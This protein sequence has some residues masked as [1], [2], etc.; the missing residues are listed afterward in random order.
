MLA[1]ELPKTLGL[2]AGA[3][4]RS[5]YDSLY[6]VAC[7]ERDAGRSLEDLAVEMEA[8]YRYFEQEK[9][10][11]RIQWGPAAFFGDGHW[12]N[13]NGWPRKAKDKVSEREAARL[14]FLNA[15]TEDGS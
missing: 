15:P 7:I 8:A 13:P 12:R 4:P 5:L 3:G 10:N 2:A 14:A 9:P 6:Q 11:L 1:K